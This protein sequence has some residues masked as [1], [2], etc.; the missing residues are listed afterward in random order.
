MHPALCTCGGVCWGAFAWCTAMP[1]LWHATTVRSAPFVSQT[2]GKKLCGG[3]PDGRV[4][5]DPHESWSVDSAVMTPTVYSDDSSSAQCS[6][7]LYVTGVHPS[8]YAALSVIHVNEVLR[9][10]IQLLQRVWVLRVSHIP[11]VL[12]HFLRVN[13]LSIPPTILL[14]PRSSGPG[15]QK[16]CASLSLPLMDDLSIVETKHKQRAR[17]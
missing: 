8:P 6:A 4:K 3:R 10:H 5:G 9:H 7:G 14:L 11:H 17:A 1:F 2:L 15:I 16:P 12:K 13:G